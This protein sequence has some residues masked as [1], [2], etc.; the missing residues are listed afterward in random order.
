MI[1]NGVLFYKL[2][3]VEK[4]AGDIEIENGEVENSFL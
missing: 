2:K 3:K 1:L 4:I